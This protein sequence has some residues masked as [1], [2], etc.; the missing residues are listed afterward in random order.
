MSRKSVAPGIY[1]DSRNG[2]FLERPTINGKSTWRKIPARSLKDAKELLS[3][4]RTDQARAIHGLARDPYAPPAKTVGA[5]CLEYEKRRCPDRQQHPRTGKQLAD[6]KSRLKHLV[7]FFGSRQVDTLKA[8]DCSLYFNWRKGRITKGTGG[9]TT[10]LELVTLANVF[11]WALSLGKIEVN[12]IAIRQRF[13][14]GK[15]IKHSYQFMPIDA[16]ELHG[17]AGYFFRRKQ[18]EVLGWQVLLQAMTGCRTSEIVRLRWD[19]KDRNEAGFIE[20]DW[21]WLSRSKA[22]CRHSPGACRMHRSIETLASLAQKRP[23]VASQL[24]RW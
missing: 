6:E 10:D 22:I 16:E 14:A 20:N 11:R 15:T 24:A 2:S 7:S 13:R 4:R 23:L 18:S 19:A 5:L 3:A 17:L 8:R 21:L 9:R 12:P 1:V